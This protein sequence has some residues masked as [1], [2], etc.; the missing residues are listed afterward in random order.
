MGHFSVEEEGRGDL[1]STYRKVEKVHNKF[2][3]NHKE[4]YQYDHI[5]FKSEGI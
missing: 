1:Q 4:N 2:S 5:P 3:H